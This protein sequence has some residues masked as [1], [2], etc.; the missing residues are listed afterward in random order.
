[1]NL[2]DAIPC[3]S[4]RPLCSSAVRV[5]D[6]ACVG[7]AQLA[8]T[9]GA[10]STR[11]GWR[12]GRGLPF[13]LVGN[14]AKRVGVVGELPE[15]D[16]ETVAVHMDD[17]SAFPR[18]GQCVR[19]PLA[20]APSLPRHHARSCSLK[21][22]AR[23]RHGL[24]VEPVQLDDRL[25]C[26]DVS[27]LSPPRIAIGRS[28]NRTR[29][30]RA[31]LLHAAKLRGA[32]IS[33]THRPIDGAHDS[34]EVARSFEREGLV[35]VHHIDRSLAPRPRHLGAG[36]SWAKNRPSV[37]RRGESPCLAHRNVMTMFYDAGEASW[38]EDE[39]V[40]SST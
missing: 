34:E 4:K 15:Q 33:Q 28:F 18:A 27:A 14:L 37:G 17:E 16:R 22:F 10:S 30:L 5:R 8:L 3:T 7:D 36:R 1:M 21:D 26:E 6:V 40:C 11:R 19:D 20:L 12:R 39:P 9:H 24:G 29:E 23:I 2:S 25:V 38:K 35:R 32:R 31:D 13:E